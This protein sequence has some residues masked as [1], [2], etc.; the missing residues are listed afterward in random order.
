MQSKSF[1]ASAGGPVVR[2]KTFFF[3]TYEGV[4]RPNEMTLSQLVP[5][6]A[7]R[8]GDLSAQITKGSNPS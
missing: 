7:F 1:G 2:N 8:A 4:R 5:P 3:A 6:D